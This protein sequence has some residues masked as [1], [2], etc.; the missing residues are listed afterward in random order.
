[1]SRLKP[2]VAAG[3]SGPSV[4]IMGVI[5]WGTR[6]GGPWGGGGGGERHVLPPL[7]VG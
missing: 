3:T 6:G 1:M 4:S 5:W 7:A 2:R